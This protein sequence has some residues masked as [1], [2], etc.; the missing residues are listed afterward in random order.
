MTPEQIALIRDSF[1]HV[2]PIRDQAADLFYTRLFEIAPETRSLFRSDIRT[3]GVKLMAALTMV[4][5]SLDRLETILDAVQSMARRHVHY[6]VTE[7]QYDTVGEALL[8]TLRKGLG[9]AFTAEVELA[10]TTAY[11]ALAGVMI[12]AAREETAA[13]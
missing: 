5:N 4:V 1:K 3:Q 8:W 10:W 13:A 12:A 11:G 6:G 7:A 2:V 9:D